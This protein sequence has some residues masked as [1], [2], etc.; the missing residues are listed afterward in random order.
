MSNQWFESRFAVWIDGLSGRQQGRPSVPRSVEQD[1]HVQRSGNGL[2]DDLL[3]KIYIGPQD[4]DHLFDGHIIVSQM[5]TV[6]IRGHGQRCIRNRGF[7]GQ[8]GFR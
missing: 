3:G 1:H 4:G 5:P 7:P 2:G 8:F 6:V